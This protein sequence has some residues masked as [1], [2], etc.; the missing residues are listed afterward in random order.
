MNSTPIT[1]IYSLL[2]PTSE[3][4]KYIGKS[5]TPTTRLGGH[6]SKAKKGGKPYTTL[7]LWMN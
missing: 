7:I 1:Y 3:I 4:V 6:I 2:C 5:N